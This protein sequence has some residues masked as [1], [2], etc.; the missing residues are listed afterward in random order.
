MEAK[1]PSTIVYIATSIDRFIAR[2]DG[3]LDWLSDP[4][5][6]PDEEPTKM[7]DAF[8]ASIDHIVMGRNTFEKVLEFGFWPYEGTPLTVVS[9]TLTEI[10]ERLEGK[11]RISSLEPTALLQQLAEEGC[12][13]VYVDGGLTI[14]S[15]LRLD[16]IDEMVL[17]TLPILLGKGVPLFGENEIETNWEHSDTVV[18]SD[19]MVMSSYRRCR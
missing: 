19:R 4:N 18:F 13:K 6:E 10:P 1:R 2:S 5:A 14:Q 12:R 15:F 7:W 8:I 16:L 3:S 9:K 11:A 17:T